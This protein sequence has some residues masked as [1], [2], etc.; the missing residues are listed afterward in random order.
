MIAAA[1]LSHRRV[2]LDVLVGQ[3]MNPGFAMRYRRVPT[4]RERAGHVSP[5]M[6]AM[7]P[8]RSRYVRTW[9]RH[10]RQ[11]SECATVFRFFGFSIR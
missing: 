9:R 8:Q 10:A 4:M 7:Q 5:S 3:A 2:G 6:L 1:D 11:C